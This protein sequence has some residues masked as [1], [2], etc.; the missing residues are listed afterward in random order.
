MT[1]KNNL[2]KIKNSLPKKV[3]LV[4]VSKTKPI[5]DLMEAYKAGQRIFGENKVQEIV[6]KYPQMPSD[7]KWHMIGHL[8]RNK[9]KY[10]APFIDLIHGIDSLKLLREINKQAIKHD[11]IIKGLIQI[12]ISNEITKFGMTADEAQAMFCSKEFKSLNNVNIIG[13]MGMASFTTNE[14]QIRKEFLNL[15]LIFDSYKEFNP[16]MEV[17][18]MGMSGDYNLAIECGS[19]MIRI[20]SSIFG[21]R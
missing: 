15:K 16:S 1:I 2:Q 7:T 12:K 3:T 6:N 13:V 19:N 8:Q 5:E 9:V 21:S 17:I 11:R 18:S 10:L 14:S 4:A 20:G